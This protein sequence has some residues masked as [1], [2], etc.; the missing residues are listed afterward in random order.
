MR[1][2]PVHGTTID[3]SPR[4]FKTRRISLPQGVT[5]PLTITDLQGLER[6]QALTREASDF[7]D[8]PDANHG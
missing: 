7:S 1:K 2:G 4:L 8:S 3:R 6:N 5:Q